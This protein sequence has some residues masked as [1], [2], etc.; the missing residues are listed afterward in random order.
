MI[1]AF[2]VLG[3]RGGRKRHQ[4]SDFRLQEGN[5]EAF[6]F[7]SICINVNCVICHIT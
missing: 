4:A 6:V 3:K 5:G 2:A 7:G 1:Q